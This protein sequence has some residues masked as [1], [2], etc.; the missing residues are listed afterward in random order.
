MTSALEIEIGRPAH[1]H[2]HDEHRR[3]RHGARSPLPSRQAIATVAADE[4]GEGHERQR[5]VP[6]RQHQQGRG[7]QVGAERRR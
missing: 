6:A 7:E 5:I 2:E 4:H 3:C 1:E